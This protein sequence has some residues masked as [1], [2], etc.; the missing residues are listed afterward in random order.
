MG[1]NLRGG[2]TK[3]CGCLVSAGEAKI[4]DILNQ[5]HIRFKTQVVFSD[6]LSD[7]NSSLKF[8]FGVYDDKDNLL[9][10]IEYQGIQHYYELSWTHDTLAERQKRDNIK[11]EYCMK[12]SIPLIEIPY[13]KFSTFTFNDLQI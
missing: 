4:R 3:S 2:Q 1:C 13:T 12:N 5:N 6:C 8:D 9:Y 10:L 11:R 7:K